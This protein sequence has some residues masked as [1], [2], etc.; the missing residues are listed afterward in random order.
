MT[1]QTDKQYCSRNIFFTNAFLLPSVHTAN[2]PLLCT[3]QPTYNVIAPTLFC[4]RKPKHFTTPVAFEDGFEDRDV[5]GMTIL[6]WIFK[7]P[8]GGT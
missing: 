4:L 1:L 8:D 5:D 6:K 3:A 7:K 2:G